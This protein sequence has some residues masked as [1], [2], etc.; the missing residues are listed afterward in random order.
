[1]FFKR[2]ATCWIIRKLLA[3]LLLIWIFPGYAELSNIDPGYYNFGARAAA[4]GGAFTAL[5]DDVFSMIRNP[6]GLNELDA[7]NNMV[8]DNSSLL[9]L[10]SYNFAGYARNDRHKIN[11]G[12]GAA[13]SGDEALTEITFFLAA[14]A[15]LKDL[16]GDLTDKMPWLD[17]LAVGLTLK[18]LGFYFGDDPEGSYLDENGLEHQVSGSAH[19]FGIDLGMKYSFLKNHKIGILWRNTVNEIWWNSKNEVGSAQ[20]K[21][22]ENRPASLFFGYGYRKAKLTMGLDLSKA[23]H[24]DTEDELRVGI[25]YRFVKLM[26]LRAGYAE[27]IETGRNI[28]Y[29]LGT[30]FY[31]ELGRN[32]QARLDISYQII[33]AWQGHNNLKF[34][35]SLIK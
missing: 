10:E 8:L 13:W 26:A 20:G 9:T 4:M 35:L 19:G 17:S 28:R 18:Y 11:W 2:T 1:M 6:A 5:S 21:Y 22:R 15:D 29:S 16:T 14:A 32:L 23:L 31:F 25:E 34:T 27:E 12:T 3:G 24:Q 7:G 33:T 30:G